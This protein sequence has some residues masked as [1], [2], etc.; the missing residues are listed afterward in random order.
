MSTIRPNGPVITLMY[1]HMVT[2]KD[3]PTRSEA[4]A[5]R[6]STAVAVLLASALVGVSGCGGSS[7]ASSDDPRSTEVA[8]AAPTA[9]TML[10]PA[11][12]ADVLAIDGIRII[13]VRTPA[14][15][16][17]GHITGAELFDI[18]QPDFAER[19]AS[20]D[21]NATYFVY[22]RSD[23]RSGVATEM[24]LEMGFTS[25]FELRGGTVAWQQA[26]LPL[27]AA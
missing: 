21:P 22:C 3:R 8:P 12:V 27:D 5:R 2:L 4:R 18:S 15:Y 6:R 14:E 10:D 17:E 1:G 24:M 9:L 25:I 23:N 19:I 26:G 13:D 16:A 11:E 20:L 7:D